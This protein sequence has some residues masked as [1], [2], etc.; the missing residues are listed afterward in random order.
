LICPVPR[1]V[2]AGLD[3]KR[4]VEE[5]GFT[6]DPGRFSASA[7]SLEHPAVDALMAKI[8]RVGVPLVDFAGVKPYRGIV[9]GLN[10]A[11]IIDDDTKN[12]LIRQ[13]QRSTLIIKPCFKGNNI[14]RWNPEW[15]HFWMIVSSSQINISEFPAIEGY[16]QQYKSKLFKRAGS[17]NWWQLQAQPSDLKDFENTKILW[18]DLAWS[19]KFCLDSSGFILNDLCF[20]ISSSDL[21]ILGVLCS[22]LLWAFMWRNVIHGKDEVLRLKNIYMETLPIAPPPSES[23]R[24]ETEEHVS[25]LIELTRTN[26][27]TQRDLIDW[28]HIETNLEKSSRKLQD[29]TSLDLEDFKKEVK[30][31]AAKG[32]TF[33]LKKYREI[34]DIYNEAI[35]QLRQNNT[36]I[37]QLEHRLSD[38]V[39]QAYQLTPDEI[40]LLWETAPPRM[41][42]DPPDPLAFP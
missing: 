40:A 39:N 11:F 37:R 5:E 9:T 12:Q 22:P 28:L 2:L 41:P 15:S 42:I 13:D 24:K 1:E 29:P 19:S 6:V 18:P 14:K 34:T 3:L 8:R 25:Q 32:T 7:W 23:H 36:E 31:C 27:Q 20:G 16:L 10:E 21:W 30:K 4:Y 35:P 38:L 26:Q 17:Q 33:G